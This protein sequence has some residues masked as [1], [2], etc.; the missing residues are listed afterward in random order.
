MTISLSLMTDDLKKHSRPNSGAALA[1]SILNR[2]T[3]ESIIPC[4]EPEGRFVA[5]SPVQAC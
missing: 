1:N 3:A 2:W 5:L 4:Q